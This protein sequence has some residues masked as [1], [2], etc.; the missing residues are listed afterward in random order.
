MQ[1]LDHLTIVAP[2]LGDGVIHV[3]ECL[4]LDVPFGTRHRYMGT[5]N[6]R[7]QLGNRVYLEIIALDPDGERPERSRWFGLDDQNQVRSDW[8]DGRRLRSWVASTTDLNG[9]LSRHADIFG[10]EVPLPPDKPEFGFSIPVQGL[11]PLDGAVPS[12]IDHRDNPTSM[13]DIPDMGAR[14]VSF[15]LSHPD[16]KSIEGLY[17][18]LRIDG[19]PSI[20]VGPAAR[21]R[22]EIETPSGLRALT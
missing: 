21:Y 7:L 20:T 3:R 18:E 9:I 11:L 12:W 5:H 13:D 17:R 22:A 15:S 19:A 4:N 14:L 1:R 6:H 2:T 16:P 10:Q 8:D